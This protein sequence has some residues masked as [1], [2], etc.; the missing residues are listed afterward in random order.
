MTNNTDRC[1]GIEKTLFAVIVSVCLGTAVIVA[2]LIW[3]RKRIYKKFCDRSF[4]KIK[5]EESKKKNSKDKSQ[6]SK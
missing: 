5:T 3:Q 2:I 6:N 4:T 1:C